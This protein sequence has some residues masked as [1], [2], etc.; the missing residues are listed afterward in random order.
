GRLAGAGRA[1]QEPA[2]L[3]RDAAVAIPV[4]AAAPTLDLADEGLDAGGEDEVVEGLAV[5]QRGL[6]ELIG[7]HAQQVIGRLPIPRQ[8]RGPAV[9][10]VL[11]VVLARGDVVDDEPIPG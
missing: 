4:P 7:G 10:A 9:L 6:A 2:T 8:A 5:A 3:P 1:V 11:G